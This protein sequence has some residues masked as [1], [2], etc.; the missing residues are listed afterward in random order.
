MIT[1]QSF[2]AYGKV[3]YYPG[4]EKKGRVRNLWRIVHAENAKVG[5]RVAYFV[6]RD[7]TV[8]RLECHPFSD[9]TFEPVKGKALLFVARTQ[10]ISS[11]Q[12]FALDRPIILRKGIWHALMSVGQEAEIKITE[13]HKVIC[14]YW[15]LGF[16][17]KGL[18][19]FF[20]K[21]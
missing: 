16:R 2:K 15:P 7:K 11:V 18:D 12:C 21:V 3:I 20:K 19:D 17:A 14:R 6:L 13:N 9:E 10:N 4:K 8:T 1:P 5:W